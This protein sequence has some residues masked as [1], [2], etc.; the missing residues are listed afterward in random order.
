MAQ[1]STS[2]RDR[3]KALS[4]TGG[5]SPKPK[6]SGRGKRTAHKPRESA[7]AGPRVSARNPLPASAGQSVATDEWEEM[8][9]DAEMQ[10]STRAAVG[11]DSQIDWVEAE[12]EDAL[13]V[14]ERR[15]QVDDGE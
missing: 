10:P 8:M 4:A 5:G 13:L 1:K 9:D 14:P 12:N 7:A 3:R 15:G 2:R 6:G 11:E